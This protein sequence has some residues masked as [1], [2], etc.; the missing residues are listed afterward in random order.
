MPVA[1]FHPTSMPRY[2][3]LFLGVRLSSSQGSNYIF[4]KS[5]PPLPKQ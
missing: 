4:T 5:T 2:S 1:E 3:Q